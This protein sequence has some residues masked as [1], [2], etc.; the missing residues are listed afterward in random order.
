[1]KWADVL[2]TVAEGSAN[3]SELDGSE[4]GVV[5]ELTGEGNDPVRLALET[6]PVPMG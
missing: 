4:T 5:V 6:I 3:V 2:W 1:M